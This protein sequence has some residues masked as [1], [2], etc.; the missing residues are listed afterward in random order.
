MFETLGP[1][2]SLGWDYLW[3]STLF[4]GLGLA[5]S[6][7]L[8]RRAARAH[9][10]LL[11]SILAALITPVLAA[12]ARRCG[13]GLLSE[14]AERPASPISARAA[15]PASVDISLPPPA[16]QHAK[17]TEANGANRLVGPRVLNTTEIAPIPE[18]SAV[19]R[20]GLGS[21][22]VRTLVFGSWLILSCLAVIRLVTSLFLSV[23]L[24]LWAR[25]VHDAT[26]MAAV[27]VAGTRLGVI[28]VPDLRISS[29]ASCP[30]I[31]CWNRRPLIV[32]P[33][34]AAGAGS[35]D[36]VAVFC[37]ELAH[38]VRRD[39]L[40]SLFG[41][42]LVC[43]LPWHPLAWYARHRLGRLSELA[44]DDW[45]LAAGLPA[46]DYAE[47]LLSLVPRRSAALALTAVSSRS[48]LVGRV[49]HIL[50]ERRTSPVVGRRWACSSGLVM[51]LA[52]SAVA[53]AQN[54]SAQSTDQ[55][56][57]G[58]AKTQASNASSAAPERLKETAMRHTIR[59]TVLGPDGKPAT[60]A[61]VFWIGQRK[62]PL[63]YVALPKD[64]ESSRSRQ[65]EI[66]ARAEADAKGAFSLSALYDPEQYQR[67]DG[68]D[69]TLLAQ[70][71]GAGMLSHPVKADVGDITLR[72]APEEVIHGR[73]LTPGGMPAAD[74]RVTVNGFHNDRTQEGMFV[75]LTP[76]DEEILACWLQPRR[77]DA[78][79]RFTL[80]GVPQGTYASL[81]FWHPEYAVDEVTVNTTKDQSLTP[82]LRAF[83]I[84]P[85]KPTFT[86]TLEPARPVQGRV[87]DKET[88]KPL[89]GL[90]VEMTP[91][92][93]H[94]GMP[95]HGRTDASGGFRISGHG[96]ARMYFTSV[97]PPANSGYLTASDTDSHWPAGAKFLE[98]N[99][100]L[101][102]GRIVRGQVID[103]D[104]KQPVAGAAVV[105]Q[106]KPG[107]P[108]NRNY[109]LRNTVVTD[110]EGR[111]AI[112]TLPGQGFLAVETA[113]EKYMR[114]RFEESQ[115]GTVFPQGL[116]T[117]EVPKDGEP[118]P[119]EIGVRRGIALQA[120]AIGPDGKVVNDLIAF[121]DG[122]DARLIDIWN[123]GKAFA[124]GVFRLPGADP[125]RTYRVLFIQPER[126]IAAVVDL[127]ADPQA[128]EPIE[129]KLE[130][131]AKVHGKVVTASGS[132][133]QAGQVYPSVV[134][135]GKEGE[136]SRNDVFR[137]THIYS[138][139]LGQKA[140]LAYGEKNKLGRQGEFVI[141]TLVPGVRYYVMAGS[142]SLEAMVPVSSL[143]PGEDRD[144][145]T[146]NLKERTP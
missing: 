25:P 50:D 112:T 59:G 13:W 115:R 58:E 17:L 80:E 48:G 63:P 78:D 3:Q 87:T 28:Q 5:A 125:G 54:R 56:S 2:V 137:N 77:T 85:V 99:F 72:L 114:V 91:M 39:H 110:S 96:G 84:T 1:G 101:E 100:A 95:F 34:E 76:T 29:R 144:L 7:V 133:V 67:Y 12:T 46:T 30:T 82:G 104:S 130:T 126:E 106:P 83:E 60:N 55:G 15:A 89:A 86:H 10:V 62:P 117:I 123:Q 23:R 146:I 51:I 75:G 113:D 64:Q 41:E 26:L 65:P 69:V 81:T 124:D 138:N 97:Y 61:T 142:G 16:Q 116:A 53:L 79:G 127:K 38:W 143:K 131:C 88:G 129:V 36:W 42:V 120:K 22:S 44:C 33:E 90:L 21:A 94:G 145:G 19:E 141:D 47:T 98:K 52:A 68:W 45:V 118:K 27:D 9:R 132:P 49:R 121:Y 122:I 102:K 57:P 108:N 20:Y 31:W 24:V 73:L 134:I 71:P 135:G 40:S 37:H 8:A 18:P 107:N 66:L 139:I 74:V 136:M 103:A 105:Y 128:R 35:V 109:D 140:M 4:L 70:A 14:G 92:R 111:F 43:A 119:V 32:L 6:V 11:L 93:S